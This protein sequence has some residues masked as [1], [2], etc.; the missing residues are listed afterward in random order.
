MVHACEEIHLGDFHQPRQN[1]DRR[2]LS[3]ED[4]SKVINVDDLDVGYKLQVIN[5]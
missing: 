5:I 4:A 2:G 3:I 1:T